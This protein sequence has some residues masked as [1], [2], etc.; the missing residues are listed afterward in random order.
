MNLPIIILSGVLILLIVVVIE[1]T[2]ILCRQK[3]NIA[4]QQNESE[5]FK[6]FRERLED[7]LSQFHLND[8]K[9]AEIMAPCPVTGISRVRPI[10]QCSF[11]RKTSEARSRLVLPRQK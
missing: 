9:L 5:I 10:K 7:K 8:E 4:F 11:L 2:V 1:A 3:R 6:E